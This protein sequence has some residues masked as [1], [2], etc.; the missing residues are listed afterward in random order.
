M[1]PGHKSS[2]SLHFYFRI[3]FIK[4]LNPQHKKA[5]KTIKTPDPLL[6]PPPSPP[7]PLHHSACNC[8]R[9][10]GNA[11]EEAKEDE[12]QKELGFLHIRSNH[13]ACGARGWPENNVHWT[14]K[15]RMNATTTKRLVHPSIQLAGLAD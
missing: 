10:D 12:G 11:E 5:E 7:L 9:T 1:L 14:T 4:Y 13:G 15:R 6:L 3:F 8:E 2:I